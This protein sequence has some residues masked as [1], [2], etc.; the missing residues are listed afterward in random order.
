MLESMEFMFP[1]RLTSPYSL[2]NG[3]E[4]VSPT[5]VVVVTKLIPVIGYQYSEHPVTSITPTIERMII[6]FDIRSIYYQFQLFK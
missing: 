2:H 6:A 3:D 5:V 4:A 1:S